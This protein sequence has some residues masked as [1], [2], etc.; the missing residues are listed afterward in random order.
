MNKAVWTS[1]QRLHNSLLSLGYKRVRETNSYRK[2][3]FHV[4]VNPKK[5]R[6]DIHIHV[7]KDETWTPAFYHHS[8][9][10]GKDINQEYQNIKRAAVGVSSRQ[11]SEQP[12]P[13]LQT[14]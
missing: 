14:S 6:V 13:R 7:D 1:F 8:R 3:Q 4:I 5:S 12:K 2:G 9:K 10:T 11:A